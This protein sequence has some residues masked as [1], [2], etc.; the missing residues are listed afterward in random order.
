MEIFVIIFFTVVI[1]LIVVGIGAVLWNAFSSAGDLSREPTVVGF[2]VEPFVVCKSSS[3]PVRVKFRSENLGNEQEV[4]LTYPID[5]GQ[6]APRTLTTRDSFDQTFDPALFNIE[7]NGSHY[8]DVA[9]DDVPGGVPPVFQ[10]KTIMVVENGVPLTLL[11]YQQEPLQEQ[12]ISDEVIIGVGIDSGLKALSFCKGMQIE[13]VSFESAFVDSF[14]RDQDAV[15][16]WLSSL[17]LTITILEDSNQTNSFSISAG[18]NF[19]LNGLLVRE[20]MVFRCEAQLPD[21][22]ASWPAMTVYR[23]RINLNLICPD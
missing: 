3:C 20:A 6:G 13:S 21:G 2:S 5:N 10:T 8:F 14:G 15:T 16:N 22:E 19:G 23:P 18:D 12:T 11:S 1:T 17:R 9:I 7:R 4:Q